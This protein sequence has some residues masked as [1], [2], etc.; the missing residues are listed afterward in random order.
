MAATPGPERRRPPVAMAERR[1]AVAQE[2]QRAPLHHA[3]E[4]EEEPS[5]TSAGTEARQLRHRIPQI[6][7][8]RTRRAPPGGPAWCRAAATRLLR[9]AELEAGAGPVDHLVGEHGGDDLAAQP[10]GRASG[11]RSARRLVRGSSRRGRAARRGRRAGPRRRISVDAGRSSC[12]RAAPRTRASSARRRRPGARRAACR[13]AGTRARGRAARR[14]RGARGSGRARRPSA[15]PA[16]AGDGQRQ[17]SGPGCRRARAR[18]PRRS[19]TRSKLV[20]LLRRSA[21]RR[22][23]RASSRILMFTSWSRAVDA[24]R[25]VDGVGVDQP[26]ARART[27]RAPAG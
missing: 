16:T 10:V 7:R 24:G 26:A 19:S 18:R 23:R 17:R 13:S 8:G 2:P 15:P 5:W 20:A 11:R 4:V 3:A 6:G 27:R 25:V 21:R 14:A 12:R 9:H 22:R 1:A